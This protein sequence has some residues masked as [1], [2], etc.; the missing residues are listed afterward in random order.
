MLFNTARRIPLICTSGH[1][2]RGAAL[3]HDGNRIAPAGLGVLLRVWSVIAICD[4][5]AMPSARVA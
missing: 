4:N 1:G 5:C 3:E 2:P